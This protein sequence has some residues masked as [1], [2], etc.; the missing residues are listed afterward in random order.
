MTEATKLFKESK[1]VKNQRYLALDV[2]RGLTVALMILV[3]TPGSWSHIYAPFKHA[4]WHGFTPTDWVFPSF[5]FVI[6]NAMSFSLRKYE[7]ISESAFLGKVFKRAAL[8][9]LIGL[10]LSAFPFVYRQEGELIFK[11][12]VNMRIM[13]VLQRIALCYLFASL[14]LHY[15]KLKKSIIFG[16]LILLGYWVI[17]WFFGD[18]PNPLSLEHNAALKFDQLIFNDANLY[19]GYGLPFD[20]EGLLSTLPAIVNVIAGYV[21]GVFIQKS[22]NNISTVIKLSIYGVLLLIVAQIW[23]IWFPINKPIWSSSYVLYSTGWT[24]LVLSA[25]ILIIEIFNFKKWTTFFEA[26]GKNPLF[27][28]VMSGLVVMLMNIIY[29]NGQAL[30]PWLY[31]NLYLSWLNNYNASLL[32]AI[33]YMLLMWLLGYWLHKKRIYIKV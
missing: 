25:L 8:I 23:D 2:L 5:L 10:F 13:G 12:L 4:P 30:K 17:M 3:N 18:Q 6:G 1:S 27:V 21:A 31:E 29:V 14:I 11:N 20:P 16:S 19:K 15:L 28:F 32:F 24:L 22:G 33:S 7:S 26:F 9:F